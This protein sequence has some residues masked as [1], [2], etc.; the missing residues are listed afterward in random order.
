M[1]CYH[2]LCVQRMH[3]GGKFTKKRNRKGKKAKKTPSHLRFI[4]TFATQ[5]DT[6]AVSDR[7]RIH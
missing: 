7:E 4:V 5:S 6:N 3:D 1:V 2:S